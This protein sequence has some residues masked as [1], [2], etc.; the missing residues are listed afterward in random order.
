LKLHCK[1]CGQPIP[2]A[3]IN[4]ASLVAVC[5]Q[6]DAVFAIAATE[7]EAAP[8][9]RKLKK[10]THFTVEQT[11]E[12]LRI[13]YNWRENMGGMEKGLTALF[14]ALGLGGSIATLLF[15]ASN[16]ANWEMGMLIPLTV[17]L[18]IALPFSYLATA[19]VVNHTDITLDDEQLRVQHGPLYWSGHRVPRA[20][21]ERFRSDPM[22][23]TVNYRYLRLVETSGAQ[24]TIEN[25][26]IGP[27][28]YLEHRL[29]KALN[30]PVTGQPEIDLTRLEDVQIGD[31]GELVLPDEDLGALLSGS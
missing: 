14:G 18:A 22:E 15:L 28:H 3:S 8:A 16:L 21:I 9:P 12:A 11:D 19:M 2:A 10:P 17:M 26:Q 13:H 25:M 30:G 31:D 23:G 1:N 24:R 6:C 7:L 20:D 29:N 4:V 27:A 5:P